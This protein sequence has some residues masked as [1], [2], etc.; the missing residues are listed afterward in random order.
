MATNQDRDAK[1]FASAL[2]ATVLDRA[3]LHFGNFT[4]TG[5]PGVDERIQYNQSDHVENLLGNTHQY[6]FPF[7]NGRMVQVSLQ[8]YLNVSNYYR[9][10]AYTR[11]GDKQGMTFSVNLTTKKESARAIFLEQ[12]IKFAERYDG[13]ADGEAIRRQ[14]QLLLA[15]ILR[16]CGMDVDDDNRLVL[17]VFDPVP[18]KL[19]NTTPEKFLNDFL[20]AALLKGHFQGNKG[21]ELDLL[22]SLQRNYD[23]F[24]PA[25]AKVSAL[26]RKRDEK[27]R[28]PIP[29]AIRYKVL[30]R[31]GS[32]CRRCGRNPNDG[33]ILHVDHMTPVSKGGTNALENLWTLCVDC[34]LGK[35]NRVIDVHEVTIR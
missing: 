19:L 18:G 11:V 13:A 5:R 34:N 22:P 29:L 15:D 25:K 3:T 17:G 26:R 35:G 10:F 2:R 6:T 31:D 32:T 9:L 20:V 4:L 23:L 30:A 7:G 28:E 24:A 27:K 33:T 21:Y 14:K 1:Q 16:R 12:A 8:L